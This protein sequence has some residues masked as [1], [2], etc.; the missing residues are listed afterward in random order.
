EREIGDRTRV[1]DGLKT[2][3]ATT[4]GATSG[5]V[6]SRF[7]GALNDI[8]GQCGLTAVVVNSRNPADQFN[9]GGL[10]KVTTPSGLRSKLKKQKDFWVISGELEGR[11]SLEQVLRA[12]ATVQVQP[13]VHRVDGFT[14]KPEGKERDAFSLRLAVSTILMPDL[15]PKAAPDLQIK[16]VEP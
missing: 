5:E 4:L 7:R 16:L 15:A 1:E 14:I 12:M 6:A 3:G 2:L 10:S 13:W 8:A 11:G 9:P